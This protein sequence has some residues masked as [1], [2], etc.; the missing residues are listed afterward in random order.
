MLSVT[1]TLES[2]SSQLEKRGVTAD[3]RFIAG[4]PA[5]IVVPPKNDATGGITVYDESHE[6]T[7]ELGGKHHSHFQTPEE[8][9]DLVA[10]IINERVCVTVDYLGDRCIGSSHFYLDQQGVRRETLR[11]S[12]TGLRGGNIRSERFL[13]SGPVDE[14][15]T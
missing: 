14:Q 9:A 10:D 12:L 7:V 5:R 2:V 13:W 6:L 1:P 4:P 15:R 3:L 8:A 11:D